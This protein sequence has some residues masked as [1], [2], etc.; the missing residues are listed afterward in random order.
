[1]QTRSRTCKALCLSTPYGG[2]T[3]TYISP[4]NSMHREASYVDYGSTSAHVCPSTPHAYGRILY[5]DQPQPAISHRL[6]TATSKLRSLSFYHITTPPLQL[7]QCL[8]QAALKVAHP[9]ASLHLNILF[10]GLRGRPCIILNEIAHANYV[11]FII[12]RNRSKMQ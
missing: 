2:H 9:L 3:T 7:L 8:S 6:F 11:V 5:T 1:M 4:A 12:E 10:G